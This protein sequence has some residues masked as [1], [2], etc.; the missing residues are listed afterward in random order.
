[1]LDTTSL[2][3]CRT[4]RA[5]GRI[6]LIICK[7]AQD[8][9][10]RIRKPMSRPLRYCADGNLPNAS[11]IWAF[12]RP[13]KV[14]SASSHLASAPYIHFMFIPKMAEFRRDPYF[15]ALTS[16]LL[17]RQCAHSRRTMTSMS[18]CYEMS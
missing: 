3:F 6:I 5:I 2:H 17:I 9:D 4:V 1:M 14:P 12:Q 10:A 7:S 18:S 8:S 16:D 15:G 13:A 11:L